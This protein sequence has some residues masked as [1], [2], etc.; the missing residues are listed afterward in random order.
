MEYFRPLVTSAQIEFFPI[1]PNISPDRI[2]IVERV[3][4]PTDG[5]RFL[6]TEVL[7][8]EIEA[9]FEDISAAGKGADLLISHPVTFATPLVAEYGRLSWASAVL[10]PTSFFS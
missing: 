7:F 9:S 3:M 6:L 1:R 10:A 4:H 5:S 2:D 8:P